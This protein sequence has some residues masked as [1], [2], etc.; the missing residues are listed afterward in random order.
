MSIDIDQDN[1]DRPS[2]QSEI[3]GFTASAKERL[4]ECRFI[5][6]SEH[7]IIRYHTLNIIAIICDAKKTAEVICLPGW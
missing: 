7:T 3:H 4:V 6:A 1:R 2:C 5:D